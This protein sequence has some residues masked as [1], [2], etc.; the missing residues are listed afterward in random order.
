MIHCCTFL[1]TR[2][3][4]EILLVNIVIYNDVMPNIRI[5]CNVNIKGTVG[6]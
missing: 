4:L 6:R 1:V 5:E 2:M 3:M